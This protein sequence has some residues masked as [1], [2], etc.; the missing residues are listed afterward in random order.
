FLDTGAPGPRSRMLETIRVFVAERL[1][2]RPDAAEVEARHAGYYRALAEQADRPLRGAG[3]GEWLERLEAEAGNP[4][5]PPRRGLAPPV[6]GPVAVL[7]PAG[8]H[9]RGRRWGRRTA[10]RRPC[11]RP[12]R[13]RRAGVGRD[14]D[15]ER[16]GRRRGGPGRPPAP[17]G[18][19]GHGRRS[20]PA[21]GG[22]AGPGV[23]RADH[24]RLRRPPAGG[25][26]EA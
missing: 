13:P 12:A 11:P 17:G 24:R 16:G 23:D 18:A 14:G 2:A 20:L 8:P 1:A 5:P 7:V 10:A 9:R 4:A 3:Q 21:R 26:G 19:A 6:P 22:P 25:S 15:R